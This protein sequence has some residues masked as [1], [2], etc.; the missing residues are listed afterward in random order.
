MVKTFRVWLVK[1]RTIK[2][3]R[4]DSGMA[5]EMI[6]VLVRFLRNSRMTAAASSEPW[7][8][9]SMRFLIDCRI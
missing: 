1:Y 6:S 5:T 9:C 4:I 7:R 8:A 2:V 3:T